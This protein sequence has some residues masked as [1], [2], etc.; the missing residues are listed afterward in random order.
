MIDISAHGLAPG[1][2]LRRRLGGSPT[3]SN[4]DP[5]DLGAFG[6]SLRFAAGDEILPCGSDE[7]PLLLIAGTAGET[8]TLD[9]RRRQI[10]R[11]RLPGDLIYACER[12]AVRA[13]GRVAVTDAKP[14]L[15]RL[16]D[17]EA[18]HQLRRAW[19]EMGKLDQDLARDH[20]VRLGRM[21]SVERVAHFLLETHARL[22]A[23]GLVEGDVFQLPTTQ[24]ALSD[25]LGLSGVHLSRTLQALR[26]DDLA[27]LKGGRVTL[28][29]RDRLAALC[30]WQAPTGGARALRSPV[31][32]RAASTSAAA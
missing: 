26:R 25:L 11:L 4:L 28:L 13:L 16:G 17:P 27:S 14:F 3:G 6:P 2:L 31:R 5:D 9:A 29:D 32:P 20:V 23:I 10:L 24:E 8:R 21:S 18:P 30:G 19:L 22:G 15:K 7:G 12:D 1:E